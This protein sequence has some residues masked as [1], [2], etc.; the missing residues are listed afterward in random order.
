MIVLVKNVDVRNVQVEPPNVL[1]VETVLVEPKKQS[2]LINN[3][4]ED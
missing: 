4:E 1:V 3:I 2:P